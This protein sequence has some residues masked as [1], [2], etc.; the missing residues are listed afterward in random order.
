MKIYIE[1]EIDA[2]IVIT[3]LCIEE[4]D[5]IIRKKAAEEASAAFSD[6]LKRV[7]AE[8]NA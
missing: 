8:S 6:L 1:V 4:L 2:S 5:K 7:V 3:S